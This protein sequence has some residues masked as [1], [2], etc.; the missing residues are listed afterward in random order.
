MTGKLTVILALAAALL[1]RAAVAQEQDPDE[2]PVVKLALTPAAEPR[3]AL[4]YRLLPDDLKRRPGNAATYYYR[5]MIDLPGVLKYVHDTYGEDFDRW[6]EMPLDELPK[7][8]IHKCLESFQGAI[9]QSLVEATHRESCD[10]D[11]Q[12]QALE[13]IDAIAFLLPEYQ[14][15]RYLGR[16]LALRARLEIAERRF[17]DALFTMQMCYQ[18]GRDTGKPRFLVTGLIG[19]AQARVMNGQLL[20]LIEAPGSPNL[21]WAIAGLP[22]PL[23]DLRPA[24]QLEISL[25]P[26]MFPILRDAE[27][28]DRS[29]DQWRELLARTMRDLS[30]VGSGSFLGGKWAAGEEYLTA[31]A[32]VLKGYPDAKRELIASGMSR[33]EVE[34]MPVGQ[35]V[36]IQAARGYQYIADEF[37]KWSL[38]PYWQ[39]IEKM[40]QTDAKLWKEGYLG[41]RSSREIFPIASLLLPATTAALGASVRLERDLAALQTI[42]AIRMYAANHG[43]RL[44]AALDD[45]TAV[46]VPM[47]PLT[48]QP[49]PYR[50]NGDTAILDVPPPPGRL[51]RRAGRR[52]EITIAREGAK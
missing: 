44:P 3:P 2:L 21:Y 7:E 30:S 19:M 1:P 31:T 42:E 37:E 28:A 24:V 51:A 15:I 49:L 39:A 5:A 17:D 13:G 35:V 16:M 33:E 34:A 18:M 46:P 47:N 50:L 9:L 11:L 10:W 20:A 43:G 25:G 29:P 12:E 45:I 40:R 26:R 38:L 23:V 22:R 14:Q 52:Y 48:N 4:R 8:K 32:L 41:P 6:R 36:A 27:T